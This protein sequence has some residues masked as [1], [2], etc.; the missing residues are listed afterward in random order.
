MNAIGQR[1]FMVGATA[2]GKLCQLMLA[3]RGFSVTTV[4]DRNTRVVPPFSCDLF[5]DKASFDRKALECEAF[6]VCI[7]GSHG[8][9]RAEYSRHL[10]GLGLSPLSAIHPTAFVGETVN[11]GKG[12]QVMPGAVI[13]DFAQV[14]DWCI[15]N[16][17]CTVD[18]DCRIGSGVHVMGGASLAGQVTIGDFASVGTNATILPRISIGAGAIIGAG[19]VVTK[20]V[21]E[22]EIVVGVPA[23]P[24]EKSASP[25]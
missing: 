4:F 13:N 11:L 10:I 21:P 5:H 3:K 20:D 12:M 15:L 22:G 18:H 9:D 7:G 19:A 8:Q 25:V 1:V 6:L 17:S 14:G 23:R 24:I 2:Q 16:S